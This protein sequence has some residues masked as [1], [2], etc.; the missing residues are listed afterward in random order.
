MEHRDQL[1]A[2][3]RWQQ[4]G[5]T[6]RSTAAAPFYA[7]L[8]DELARDVEEDGPGSRVLAP[9][10]AEPYEA[11]YV[12]RLLG[13]IH[14]LVLS[15]EAPALARHFPS[16]GGDGDPNAAWLLIEKVV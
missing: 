10:A 5:F 4:A 1:L 8:C 15:G 14:R 6:A 16:T 12:L 13:G 11:A 9:F 3:I 2:T 7:A